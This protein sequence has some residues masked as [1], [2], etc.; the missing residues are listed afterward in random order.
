MRSITLPAHSAGTIEINRVRTAH[1][2]LLLRL[3]I[4]SVEQK[5][6][7]GAR[8]THTAVPVVAHFGHVQGFGELTG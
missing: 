7:I 6:C 4:S 8:S 3:Y 5:I 1:N 2:L